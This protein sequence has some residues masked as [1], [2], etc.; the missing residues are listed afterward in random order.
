MDR[1][2]SGKHKNVK[3][4]RYQ[5]VLALCAVFLVF[6]FSLSAIRFVNADS[7]NKRIELNKKKVTMEVGNSNKLKVRNLPGKPLS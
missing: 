3:K 5:G 6:C 4:D 2:D 7:R 1:N